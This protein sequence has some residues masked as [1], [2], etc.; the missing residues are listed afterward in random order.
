M[1]QVVPDHAELARDRVWRR[2]SPRMLVLHPIRE[3]IRAI[4][5]IVALLFAGQGSGHGSRWGLIGVAVVTLLALARWFTTRFRITPEQV[6]L[7]E[8]VIRRRTVATPLDRVRTV[9]VTSH[10]L[11]RALGLARVEI[12][13][14]GSDRSGRSTLKLDG[15]GAQE[16]TRLRAELLH[17]TPA[18]ADNAVSG[19]IHARPADA[20]AVGDPEQL[21][22]QLDPWWV[23]FAPFTLSGAVTG[24][25][26]LAFGW[27]IESETN[28]DVTK[29]GPFRGVLRHLE[30]GS[31]PAAVIEV[32]VV[33]V[34]FVAL[35]SGVRYLLAFW[36]FRLSRHT[37]GSLHIS[38]GLLTSRNT[39]IEAR[40][41]RGVSIREP[42]L[43]RLVG[44]ARITAVATGLRVGRGSDRGGTVLLPDAPAGEAFRVAGEIV[45]SALPVTALLRDHGSQARRRRYSRALGGWAVVS[46]MYEAV[47]L[48]LGGDDWGWLLP[49]VLLPPA[50]LLA[51]DRWHSLGH[52]I[53]AGSLVIRTGSFVRRRTILETDAII[54]WNVRTSFF[55]RRAG[56]V[57]L[58]ATTAA[59]RQGYRIQD[60]AG[61]EALRVARVGVPGLLSE[62]GSADGG[63]L[64]DP[65]TPEDAAIVPRRRS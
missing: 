41:L 24:L 12:G 64:L 37:E 53:V 28:V 5:A 18:R 9:D 2:L 60:V 27:R 62:F 31:V 56:L 25:A 30:Q 6:Q 51:A 40:R 7:R 34:V 26:I 50:L 39:S 61:E 21:I 17:R 45:G 23:R 42:L 36:G 44:G 22:A 49:L 57:T 47:W 43:L 3:L 65:E 8:G 14:G 20:A 4:P 48:G 29:L 33:V 15:L 10:L 16:A 46:V 19:A 55:Q 32:A 38:R 63:R 1:S 35:A 54:G 11:H 13:T 59:G 52:D 58:L